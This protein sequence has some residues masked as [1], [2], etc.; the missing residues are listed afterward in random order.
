MGGEAQ[1]WHHGSYY[2]WGRRP[3]AD[4]GPAWVPGKCGEFCVQ[5]PPENTAFECPCP[6]VREEWDLRSFTALAGQTHIKQSGLPGKHWSR[7][8][9]GPLQFEIER[10]ENRRRR[11][12]PA[13]TPNLS[14]YIARVFKP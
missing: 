13:S 2:L 14:S 1:K 11:C 6:S 5:N 8:R 9:R 10:A 7:S 3:G 4:A 12:S